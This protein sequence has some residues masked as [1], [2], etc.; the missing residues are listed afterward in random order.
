VGGTAAPGSSATHTNDGLAD[1]NYDK[2]S[3]VGAELR[4]KPML[5]PCIKQELQRAPDF[6]GEIKFSIAIG[7]DGHVAKLWMDDAQFKAG[8]LETCFEQKV[9]TWK[10]QTYVGE[11]ASLS[12]SFRVGR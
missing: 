8:P 2:N 9:Q 4:Q 6:R 7:N 10:F 1:I 11:R 3:I 5:I 12:D